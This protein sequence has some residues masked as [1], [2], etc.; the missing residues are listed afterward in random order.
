MAADAPMRRVAVVGNAGA[1]KSTLSRRLGALL[2]L[3]VVHLDSLLWR[4]GWQRAPLA[5]FMAQHAAIVA[6][7][8]WI[9]DGMATSESIA[10][11]VA[12]AD[13]I[14]FP[15]YPLGQIYRWALKRQIESLYRPRPELPGC[16]LWRKSGELLRVIWYVHTVMRPQLLDILRDNLDRK[17]VIYLRSPRETARLLADLDTR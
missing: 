1:G 14:I 16:P 6:R 15:D 12:V 3:P 7:P 9:I 11:R 5:E 4:P 17:R 13:T 8:A 10:A 2:G